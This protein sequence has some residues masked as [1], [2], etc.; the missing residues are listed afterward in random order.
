MIKELENFTS[1][2]HGIFDRHAHYNDSAFDS[3]REELLSSLPSLGVE[4]AVCVGYDLPSSQKAV[5]I[6]EQYPHIYA[7]AGFHPE[8]LEEYSEDGIDRLR[9]LLAHPKTVAIG[10]IGLDYHWKEMPPDL[11]QRAFTRQLSLAREMGLPVIIHAR[12]ATE[13]TLSSLKDFTD[14]RGVVHCFS[15]SA[16]TAKILA[17]WG[18]YIG[19]T[20]ILTFKNARHPVEACAVVPK[21]QLLLETDCPYMAPV[22]WRGKRSCSPMIQSVAERMAEIKGVSAQEMIDIAAENTRRL[23]GIGGER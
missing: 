15:G 10:E 19:F 20:G 5:E 8:N 23:F 11:Q 1:K 14:V 21:E 18:F 16:E 22:P 7:A 4:N 9:P 17:G 3:D 2:Y 6:A 12:E 13:D